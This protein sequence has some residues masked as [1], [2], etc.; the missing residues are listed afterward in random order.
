MADEPE[1]PVRVSLTQA[2]KDLLVAKL[3]ARGAPRAC[4]SCGT[5][6][7][8]I[9]EYLTS[10]LIVQRQGKGITFDLAGRIHTSTTLICTNCGN[11]KLFNVNVLGASADILGREDGK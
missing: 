10:P 6:N 11:T 7:W 9:G 1:E 4:E 2:E 5:D 3:K 8:Q